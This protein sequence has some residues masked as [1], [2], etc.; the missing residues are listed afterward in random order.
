MIFTDKPWSEAYTRLNLC[1]GHIRYVL[2]DDEDT[3][4]YSDDGMLIDVGKPAEFDAHCIMV[5]SSDDKEGWSNPLA[6]IYVP[7]R[8]DLP[9]R[10]QE[11]IFQYR[12]SLSKDR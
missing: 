1:G 3:Q 10:I 11:V 6:E 2:A 4:I 12:Q 7:D 5:L 8:R 9:A